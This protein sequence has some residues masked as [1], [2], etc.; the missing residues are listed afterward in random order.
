MARIRD[1]TDALARMG[2]E[3]GA[4]ANVRSI[5]SFDYPVGPGQLPSRRPPIGTGPSGPSPIAGLASEAPWSRQVAPPWR[6][7]LGPVSRDFNFQNF[8]LVLP[9]GVG[10]TVQGP[11]FRL[12]TANVGWLQQFQQYILSQTAATSIE[13]ILQFNGGPVPGFLNKRNP[14]GVANL[15]LIDLNGLQVRVPQGALVSVLIR[16]LN[17]NG[18]WTVGTGFA[19]WQHSLQ[20]ELDRWGPV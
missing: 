8:E 14:P 19:G 18:P 16:N 5:Q 12:P 6:E 13:W 7:K 10:S 9:A 17:V 20:A 3:G 4:G 1:G 2:F 15:V 11:S